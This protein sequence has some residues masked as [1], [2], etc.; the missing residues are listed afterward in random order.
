MFIYPFIKWYQCEQKLGNNIAIDDLEKLALKL[1]DLYK[2]KLG[3]KYQEEIVKV[4]DGYMTLR[5]SEDAF[6]REKY[7]IF[8]KVFLSE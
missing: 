5:D 3:E 4:H 2:E 1:I 8:V 6:D 7:E